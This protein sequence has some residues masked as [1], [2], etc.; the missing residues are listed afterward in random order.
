M[1]FPKLTKELPT[2]RK[3]ELNIPFENKLKYLK[4][5]TSNHNTLKLK[6]MKRNTK[7]DQNFSKTHKKINL[8]NL[9]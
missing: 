2:P 7:A 9:F 1:L 3:I 8:K 4:S 5:L 6:N